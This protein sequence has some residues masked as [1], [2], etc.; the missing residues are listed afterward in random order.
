MP[1]IKVILLQGMISEE[2]LVSK[3]DDT[4]P[5]NDLSHVV[6]NITFKSLYPTN[7][8][9]IKLSIRENCMLLKNERNPISL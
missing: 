9:V 6:V 8:R 2:F 3:N 1:N 5:V 7:C 4:C